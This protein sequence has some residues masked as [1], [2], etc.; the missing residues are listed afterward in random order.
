[1]GMNHPAAKRNAQF[2]LNVMHWLSGLLDSPPGPPRHQRWASIPLARDPERLPRR[3]LIGA[4]AYRAAQ[5]SRRSPA[6]RG[7][8]R[9]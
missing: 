5:S 6:L 3:V 4:L 7:P 2:P 1:M 9:P 8:R